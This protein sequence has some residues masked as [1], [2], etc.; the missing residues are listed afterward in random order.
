NTTI[1]VTNDINVTAVGKINAGGDLTSQAGNITLNTAKGGINVTGNL[2]AGKDITLNTGKDKVTLNGTALNATRNVSVTGD[3]VSLNNASLNAGEGNIT[4]SGMN[5][6]ADIGIGM[7]GKT[8]LKASAGSITLNASSSNYVNHN[9]TY[10]GSLSLIK[11]NYSFVSQNTTI[12]ARNTS[13]HTD[14]LFNSSQALSFRDNMTLSFVGNTTINADSQAGVGVYFATNN[15]DDKNYNI[16]IA[17]GDL[18]I[19]ATG[20]TNAISFDAVLKAEGANTI[21]NFNIAD[22]STLNITGHSVTGDAIT[23]WNMGGFYTDGQGGFVFSGGG[24]ALVSGTS[25]YGNGVISRYLKNTDLTGNLTIHGAST[26]GSGVLID[27]NVQYNLKN[28]TITGT[29]QTGSGISLA[30]NSNR[31]FNLNGNT[32]CG[33]TTSGAAGVSIAGSK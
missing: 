33:T 29:S 10:G 20:N 27:K 15:W 3:S 24:D 1:N 17:N 28:A 30:G 25:V 14:V 7:A 31:K 26:S 8:G 12:N 18:N 23:S 9:T 16:S 21:A 22:D 19:N 5:G 11:G 4:V 32:L 13:N 2:T 6:G